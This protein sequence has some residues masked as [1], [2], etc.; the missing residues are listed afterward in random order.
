MKKL[1][2]GGPVKFP[3]GG[4]IANIGDPSVHIPTTIPILPASKSTFTQYRV[5]RTQKVFLSQVQPSAILYI[6]P[7]V[8]Y[9]LS[10]SRLL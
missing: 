10:T 8:L 2:N 1:N 6:S 9:P 3:Q 7:P 4:F 5:P